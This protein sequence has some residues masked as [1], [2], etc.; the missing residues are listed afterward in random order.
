[1]NVGDGV[2]AVPAVDPVVRYAINRRKTGKTIYELKTEAFK[3]YEKKETMLHLQPS[4]E[5][6]IK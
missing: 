1:M 4:D 2:A 5:D 3:R 6:A